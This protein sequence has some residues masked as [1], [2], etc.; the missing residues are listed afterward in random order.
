MIQI[1]PA[2]ALATAGEP[3][4]FGLRAFDAKGNPVAVPAGA[5]WSLEGLA[6]NVAGGALTPEAGRSQVGKVVAKLS[7]L[8]ATARVRSIAPLRKSGPSCTWPT[9][10]IRTGTPSRETTTVCSMSARDC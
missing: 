4:R 8:T 5:E 3:V 1:E 9:S 6:G 7:G 2:E 10:R